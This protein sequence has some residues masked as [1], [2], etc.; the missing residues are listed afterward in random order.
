MSHRRGGAKRVHDFELTLS[1]SP[2]AKL[3]IYYS[4]EAFCSKLIVAEECHGQSVG[5]LGE[6]E[7]LNA[8]PLEDGPGKHFHCYLRTNNKFTITELRQLCTEAIYASEIIQDSIHIS[9]I[10]NAEHWIKYITKEDTCPAFKGVS[11]AHFHF[12]YRAYEY[13]ARNRSFDENSAFIRQFPNYLRIIREMHTAYW[14]ARN[15]RQLL[16]AAATFVPDMAVPWVSQ[17]YDAMRQSKHVLLIG[18]TG[19]GKS[20]LNKY[21]CTTNR[22]LEGVVYLPCDQS[23]FEFSQVD[24]NTAVAV[25]D[26]ISLEY[27]VKHRQQ[28]LRLLDGGLVSINPK[29]SA[30]RSFNCKAQF[31]FCSNYYGL[32]ENDPAFHRRVQVIYAN[33]KGFKEVDLSVVKIEN[34]PVIV[35]DDDVID[36]SSESETDVNNDPDL[37]DFLPC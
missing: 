32:V 18:D 21:Y 13:V 16:K 17:A 3:H 20:I 1:Q 31:I 4:L 26:D 29:C 33:C 5:D 22:N 34:D 36:I 25:A 27:I 30:V 37:E 12:A 7:L 10:R 19:L 14:L 6:E 2:L 11:S 15:T 24:G 23:G 35:E 9:T 28:L 8:V